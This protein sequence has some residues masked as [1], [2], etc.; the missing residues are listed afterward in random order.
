M[1]L[2]QWFN[3][4]LVIQIIHGLGT[5]KLYQKAGRKPWEAFVPI[6]NALVLFRIMNRP[7]YWIFFIFLPVINCVMFPVIWVETARSFGKNSTTDTILAVVSL[8]FYNYYLN[9]FL[10]LK[11]VK[12]RDGEPKSS[13]GQFLNSI[14]YAIVVASA[15]HIYF[16]QPFI[17]PSSSLEK[18]LLVG[19]AL[20]VS[21]MHYGARVPMT[22]VSLPMVHDSIPFTGKKSYLFSD[23]IEEKNTSWK[24]KLQLP[25][26]RIPGWEK[27]K[28]N[29]IVVFNQPA[30]TLLDM[31]DFTPNRNYYKPIDKKTNLVKR[32]V[33][34][35]G[36]TLEIID[37]YVYINGN[38]NKLPG[39]AKLQFT[40]T[41]TLKPGKSFSRKINQRLKTYYDITDGIAMTSANTFTLGAATIEN[42]EKFANHPSVQSIEKYNTPKNYIDQ[43]AFPQDAANSWNNSHF[44]P[45]YIPKQGATIEINTT[46]L[47]LYKRLIS[48]YEG[49]SVYAKGNQIYI[50]GKLASSYT[51]KQNY[52]WMM[53]D[54]RDRSADA[55]RWGFVPE[56]HVVGKPVFIWMSWNTNG[57][58]LNKIRWDRV[59][60]TVHA[61]GPRRSYLIHFVVLLLLNYGYRKWKKRKKEAA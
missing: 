44:G 55:R 57:K 14:L 58:G 45:V 2:I 17:I 10:D 16:L 51:F 11:H 27:I 8:G 54:N 13:A 22:T 56:N 61:D 40:H 38:K 47:P 59:F 6:Y 3:F 46:N 31:N 43:D 1:T 30:D 12:N 42:A 9:Y 53:G 20:I 24:N 5:W 21:K 23:K 28:R 25:Y 60:T 19:D 32:C 18:S 41:G 4:I 48:E 37:G 29:E 33:G 52:Y 49:N 39:R 34:I 36:D 15:V 26:L 50:N 7:W 35:A